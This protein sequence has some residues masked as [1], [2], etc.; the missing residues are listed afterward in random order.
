MKP[1][2]IHFFSSPDEHH[3]IQQDGVLIRGVE[4]SDEGVYRCRARVADLGT[5]DSRDIQVQVHVPP[6]ITGPPEVKLTRRIFALIMVC[7]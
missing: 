3:I 7:I 5:L 6:E 1:L 2:C 4:E